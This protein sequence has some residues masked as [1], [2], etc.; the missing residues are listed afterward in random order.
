MRTIARKLMATAALLAASAGTAEALE[1]IRMSEVPA[2]AGKKVFVE[3]PVEVYHQKPSH[4]ER[5][6]FTGDEVTMKGREKRQIAAW[7][8]VTDKEG[9]DW[10]IMV[11]K[12]SK[13]APAYSMVATGPLEKFLPAV[14][15]EAYEAQWK[16]TDLWQGHA[17]DLSHDDEVRHLREAIE[18]AAL[19]HKN[20]LSKLIHGRESK[21]QVL[22]QEGHKWLWTADASVLDAYCEGMQYLDQW[23]TSDLFKRAEKASSLVG[24]ANNASDAAGEISRVKDEL[25]RKPWRSDMKQDAPQ[26]L[27]D[28][29]DKDEIATREKRVAELEKRIADARVESTRGRTA[30]GL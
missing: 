27:R 28:S 29:V 14:F 11:E 1:P 23:K 24:A 2:L 16:L 30:L 6:L 19:A 17:Y 4:A 22:E 25:Q 26:A 3:V 9:N 12:L 13:T 8:V 5:H 21:T 20:L 7:C 18:A 10:E 15:A